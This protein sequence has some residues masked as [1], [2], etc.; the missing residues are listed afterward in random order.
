M[1]K[2]QTT[3]HRIK[4]ALALAALA[5]LALVTSPAQTL[6]LSQEPVASSVSTN[7]DVLINATNSGAG[8]WT[9]KRAT[10]AK[11]AEAITPAILSA[12]PGRT[13]PT[14]Y[15]VLNGG[16]SGY[17]TYTNRTDNSQYKQVLDFVLGSGATNAGTRIS[18][19]QTPLDE[20]FGS[21]WID[22]VHAG[23]NF[24]Q[25]GTEWQFTSPGH[26]AFGPGWG[27]AN[28]GHIQIGIGGGQYTGTN[29][30]CW[31]YLTSGGNVGGGSSFGSNAPVQ[32][33]VPL[34]WRADGYFSAISGVERSFYPGIIS[35]YR[36]VTTNTNGLG[37]YELDIF[38]NLGTAPLGLNMNDI[39]NP[40]TIVHQV[41][42]FAGDHQGTKTIGGLMQSTTSASLSGPT[43]LDFA[44]HYHRTLT[45]GTN[46]LSFASTNTLGAVAGSGTYARAVCYV[47]AA[48]LTV[49][50]IS[51]PVGWNTNGAALPSTI[52]PGKLVRLELEW[53]SPGGETN[54]TAIS[55]QTYSDNSYVIDTDANAFAARAGLTNTSTFGALN[56]FV[57]SIKADGTWTNFEAIYPFSATGAASNALN[58]VSTNYTIAWSGGFDVMDAT[59]IQSNGTNGFG[60]TGWIPSTNQTGGMFAFMKSDGN[61]STSAIMGAY[62]NASFDGYTQMYYDASGNVICRYNAQ[63][64]ANTIPL[65]YPASI[66]YGRFGASSSKIYSAGTIQT[67][68]TIAATTQTLARPIY[69]CANNND[70]TTN[71]AN[72]YLSAPAGG[73]GKIQFVA[74]GRTALSFS[75]YQTLDT[76]CKAFNSALGR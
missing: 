37:I 53:L 52:A 61:H 35:Q 21:L 24:S 30:G 49:T 20:A 28:G 6:K 8:T 57:Q 12:V 44:D 56:T 43:V 36:T 31:V 74:F 27:N 26:F 19:S 48:S 22:T 55:G 10:V 4:T 64:G 51:Y 23:G 69:I 68:D 29:G 76:A 15:D 50:N 75:Q 47:R 72:M 41:R 7:D 71:G 25:Y 65:T 67:S 2:T 59:G 16:K 45:A 62:E 18:F 33:S 13:N 9:T 40:S 1:M 42:N 14:F 60:N 34:T 70:G 54:V 38:A 39:Y 3:F 32:Y 46:N 11:V 17:V 66:Y 73:K 5:A 63:S 58:L